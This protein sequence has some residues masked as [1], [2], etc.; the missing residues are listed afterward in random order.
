LELHQ[1]LQKKKLELP[2]FPQ[3]FYF[4]NF[5][6]ERLT[7]RK[8]EL[9][10]YMKIILS[11]EDIRVL[12]YLLKIKDLDEIKDF[13]NTY[14]HRRNSFYERNSNTLT[15]SHLKKSHSIHIL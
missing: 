9:E 13:L 14:F 4:G 2:E 5:E 8:L 7:K 6:N 11:D 15:D 10:E 12:C 1:I 3:K